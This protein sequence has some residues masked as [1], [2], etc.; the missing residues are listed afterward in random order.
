ME[1]SELTMMVMTGVITGGFSAA[2]TVIA[3]KVHIVYLR[4]HV[5]RHERAIERAHSRIDDIEKKV[6]KS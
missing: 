3:L 1:G 6:N 4:E 5:E 2:T